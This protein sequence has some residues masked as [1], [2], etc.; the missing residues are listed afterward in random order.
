MPHGG[1]HPELGNQGFNFQLPN[2]TD[3]AFG[4]SPNA[5][6]VPNISGSPVTAANINYGFLDE[7]GG[8]EGQ[9]TQVGLAS[10]ILQ[11]VGS[12]ANIYLGFQQQRTA[13]DNLRF[14]RNAFNQQLARA[15]QDYRNQ[16]ESQFRR[17][18]L[19]REVS[20]DDLQAY[21]DSRTV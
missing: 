5:G 17:Q 15:D 3:A 13:R 12:L 10:P 9:Q 2:P 21:I 1:P 7:F 18:N 4:L 11:G 6:T 14:Q 16:L 20:A 19:G 8:P